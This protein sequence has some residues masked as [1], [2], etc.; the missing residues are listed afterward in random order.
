MAEGRVC[1]APSTFFGALTLQAKFRAPDHADKPSSSHRIELRGCTRAAK[2]VTET[3]AM[4]ITLSS[5][6]DGVT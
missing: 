6:A 2:Y 1:G 3:D 5:F 4:E